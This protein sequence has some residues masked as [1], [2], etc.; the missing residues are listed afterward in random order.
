VLGTGRSTAAGN[1]VVDG[2]RPLS[3]AAEVTPAAAVVASSALPPTSRPRPNQ[4]QPARAAPFPRQVMDYGTPQSTSTEALK[5]FVLNEPTV[6]APP[7]GRGVG[8]PRN[9]QRPARQRRPAPSS[10]S[11]SRPTRLDSNNPRRPSPPPHPQ[12][13]IKPLFGLQKGPTGVFKSVLDTNRTDG[14][15]RDEIFV[16]VVERLSMTFGPGGNVVASQVGVP[17]GGWR[18]R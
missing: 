11:P 8:P 18:R 6:V 15:R 12:T 9:T 1:R 10:A 5:T 2:S 17:G 4:L 13:G 14:K 3:S 7:V 16:D